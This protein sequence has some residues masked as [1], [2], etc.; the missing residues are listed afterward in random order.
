[1]EHY[2]ELELEIIPFEEEDVIVTSVL[3]P[4][5]NGFLSEDT[6]FSEIWNEEDE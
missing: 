2:E 4:V 6:L 3:L 5:V 1:M